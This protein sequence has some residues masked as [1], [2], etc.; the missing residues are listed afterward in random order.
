M[1]ACCCVDGLLFLHAHCVQVMCKCLAIFHFC[2][3]CVYFCVQN[4]CCCLHTCCAARPLDYAHCLCPWPCAYKLTSPQRGRRVQKRGN[5]LLHFG[6]SSRPTSG[7]FPVLRA[8]TGRIVF[9]AEIQNVVQM[10][11]TSWH[12]V[13]HALYGRSSQYLCTRC[14][15]RIPVSRLGGYDVCVCSE[16]ITSAHVA[17][18]LR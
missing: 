7:C 16:L 14:R 4:V 5:S 15:F 11:W 8:P 12:F 17:W 2:A 18:P 10:W 3:A 1:A 13:S 9:L 6:S